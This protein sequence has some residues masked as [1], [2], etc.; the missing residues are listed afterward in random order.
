MSYYGFCEY[1]YF[2]CIY[3]TFFAPRGRGI[4]PNEI[5]SEN[6]ENKKEI[7]NDLSA[8][9]Y[10]QEMEEVNANVVAIKFNITKDQSTVKL[11]KLASA[12]LINLF[13]ANNEDFYTI[14]S[15]GKMKIRELENSD[16]FDAQDMAHAL[17]EI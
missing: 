13:R 8:L 11:R 16:S 5:N 12:H 4:K 17:G 14:L 15:D 9:K 2:S 10:I 6:I 3:C 7:F 1:V